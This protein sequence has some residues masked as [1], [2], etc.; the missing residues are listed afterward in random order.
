MTKIIKI[1]TQSSL[2]YKRESVMHEQYIDFYFILYIHT[3]YIVLPK[4]KT[5]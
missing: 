2:D 3:V 1:K 5:Y 4:V